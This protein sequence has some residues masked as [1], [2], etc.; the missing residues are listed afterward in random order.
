MSSPIARLLSLSEEERL[1]LSS[2]LKRKLLLRIF[3]FTIAI[4]TSIAIVVFFNGPVGY[5]KARDNLEV[6]NVVFVVIIVVCA[7]FMFSEFMEYNK[8]VTSSHK[9][10][11]RTRV[12]GLDGDKIIL[13]NRSFGKEEIVLDNSHFEGLKAGDEVLLEISTRSNTIF[14]VKKAPK[15]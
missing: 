2:V 12:A 8:E 5:D 13:G 4:L 7:R 11:V 3:I 14:S 1:K 10:V 15:E 6:I 9:K